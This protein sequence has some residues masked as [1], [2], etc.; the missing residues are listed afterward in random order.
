LRILAITALAVF[1]AA[2]DEEGGPFLAP[3]EPLAYTRFINAVP[4]TGAT[5]WRFIDGVANSPFA[6]GLAFRGGTPYQATNP[7]PRQ[8]RIFPT[9]V[10]ISITTQIVID[11]TL[12]FEVGKYY[13][14]VHLGLTRAGQ[15][16]ADHIKVF[17]DTPAS[18]GTQ[19][20]FRVVNLATGL[21][22]LDVFATNT[23]GEATPSTALFSA[24]AYTAA[25]SYSLRNPGTLAIRVTSSGTTT[26]ILANAAAPAGL[27]ADPALTGSAVGGAA[28]AGSALSAFVFP[29]SVAGSRAPQTTAFQNPAIGYFVDRR[30]Q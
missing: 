9:S 5:D 15:T 3:D 21:N 26:P 20:A 7:G 18:I 13:T 1:A 29:R 16:P 22:P 4:D 2:C 6:V 12:T 14:I 24:L 25:S 11:T 10:E 19:I 17:E 8:L 30:P 28:Q 23:T 27:P